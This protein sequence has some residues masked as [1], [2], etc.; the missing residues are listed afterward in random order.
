MPVKVRVPAPLQKLTG[1]QPEIQGTGATVAEVI[2][3]LESKHP[4]VKDKLCD[5]A[6]GKVRRYLNVFV[7]DQDVRFLQGEATA[8]KDGDEMS[9][10]P[11]IA[12]GRA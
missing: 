2:A 3:S 8:V 7:N 11:A 10:V 12:G 1:N 9:I 5:P 4:G 6:T